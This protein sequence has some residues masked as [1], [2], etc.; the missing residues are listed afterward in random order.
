MKKFAIFDQKWVT[1]NFNFITTESLFQ[2]QQDS[3]GKE[4]E[5]YMYVT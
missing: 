3:D 5:M 4:S 2:S 1:K